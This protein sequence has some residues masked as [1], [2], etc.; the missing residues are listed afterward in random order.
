MAVSIKQALAQGADL[1]AVSESW[2]LEAELLLAAVL[3]KTREYLHTWPERELNTDQLTDYEAYLTRRRGGEPIAY[4]L[5]Y[6]AFWDFELTVT[7][8]VLIP[9]PETELLVEAALEQAAGFNNSSLRCA[10]LGTGSGA[11]AIALARELPS[12]T[13]TAVERS[14]AA[15]AVARDNALRLGATNIDLCQ[16]IW[17]EELATDDYDLV[18][19]NPPYVAA[20][21]PHL[22]RGDLRFEPMVALVATDAGLGDLRM[23]IGQSRRVLRHGGWLL[24][25]HGYNQ[26]PAV[27]GLFMSQGYRNVAGRQDHAGQDRITLGQWMRDKEEGDTP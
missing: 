7:P 9:R 1:E 13:I 2:R 4:I 12:A 18:V 26:G 24:V 10:D 27:R 6:R 11:I 8:A 15:L 17:C 14:P 23:I 16:G 22:A 20:D 21:D 19:S 3:G 5:G 25:E